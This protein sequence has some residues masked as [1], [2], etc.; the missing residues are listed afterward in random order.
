MKKI[1]SI[2][3]KAFIA[4]GLILCQT[5]ISHAQAPCDASFTGLTSPTCSANSPLTLT[6]TTAGGTFSGPGIAG[7]QFNP[8]T[9]GVGTHT[10]TYSVAGL[11][12][13][14]ATSAIPFVTP[15]SVD[16]LVTLSD[17][18]MTGTLPIGFTFNFFGTN[19]TQFEISSNGFW[20][21]YRF[22][23]SKYNAGI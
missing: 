12:G 13:N 2:F 5:K 18:A 15:P 11:A 4:L 9:A 19:Y 21:R 7:N 16:N 8:V 23:K 22:S 17:D 14:Y 1:Y 10:I 3:F 20:N 6:P